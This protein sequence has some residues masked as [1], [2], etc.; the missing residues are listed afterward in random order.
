MPLSEPNIREKLAGYLREMDNLGRDQFVG[1]CMGS[2]KMKALNRELDASGRIA[3]QMKFVAV[4]AIF[5]PA[6]VFDEARMG[7]R[8]LLDFVKHGTMLL[9]LI[10]AEHGGFGIPPRQVAQG[11]VN[12]RPEHLGTTPNN[13]GGLSR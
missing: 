10:E 4:P 1:C 7:E 6:P 5:D 13:A 9:V 12:R 8:L 11:L 3:R 2:M